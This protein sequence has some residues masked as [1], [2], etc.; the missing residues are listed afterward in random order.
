M[1]KMKKNEDLNTRPSQK[2]MTE[3]ENL[4]KLNQFDSLE[5]KTREVIENHP[6]VSILYNILGI[7][8]QKK[9]D[10]NESILNFNQAINIQPNF[11]LA[12]IPIM[13]RPTVT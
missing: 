3:L 7:A 9:G 4:H 11:D 2:E 1:I 12:S 13:L 10:F 8:L 5:E 6:R